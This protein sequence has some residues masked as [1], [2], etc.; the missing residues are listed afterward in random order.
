MALSSTSA[1]GLSTLTGS[2]RRGATPA[3]TE[4]RGSPLRGLRRSRPCCATICLA[5]HRVDPGV[6]G[7]NVLVGN[8]V[9]VDVIRVHVVPVDVV[10]VHV[11]VIN[12]AVYVVVV[13]DVVVVHIAIHN[14]GVNMDSAI[15]VIHVHAVDMNVT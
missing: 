6:V 15:A 12:V 3:S 5:S 10:H 1:T 9:A 4:G 7:I 11:V 8:I 2:I 13:V 14:C